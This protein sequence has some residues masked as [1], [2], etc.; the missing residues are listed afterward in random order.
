MLNLQTHDIVWLA[1]SALLCFFMQAGFLLLESGLVRSKNSINVT[2]KNI[3]DFSISMIF[4]WAFGFAIMFGLSFHGIFGTGLFLF[5]TT[6][7]SSIAMSDQSVFFLFQ[8]MFCATAVTIVSGAVAERMYFKSYLIVVAIV[9]ALVYPF[10]GHWVWGGILLGGTSGWLSEL[11]FVDFAGSLVVHGTGGWV[12]LA[13]VLILGPRRGRFLASGK[14]RELGTSSLPLAATGFLVLW[15]GWFGFNGGSNYYLDHK[16]AGILL[17]TNLAG[18]FGAITAF[19]CGWY[20]RKIASPSYLI[21]GGLG[22]LVGITANVHAV[23]EV[24]AVLIGIVSGLVMLATKFFLERVKVDDVIDVVPVHL[25]CGIWGGIAVALLGEKELLGTGLN[26]LEQLYVQSFGI[27]VSFL[28]CF[29]LPFVIFALLNWVYKFRVP[30]QWENDGL[31]L[32]EHNVSTE[33]YDF[34]Q[35]LNADVE[36]IQQLEGS[37]CLTEIGK[38]AK[39]YKQRLERDFSLQD[40]ELKERRLALDSFLAS[41]QASFT[42]GENM[43]IRGG[44][45]EGC[46]ELLGQEN[47][48]GRDVA[49]ILFSGKVKQVDFKKSFELFYDG[50]IDMDTVLRLLD[51]KTRIEAK[52]FLVEYKILTNSSVVCVLT[53]NSEK[54]RL[55]EKLLSEEEK[56]NRLIRVVSNSK[57]FD[58]FLK[59]VKG[60]FSLFNDIAVVSRHQASDFQNL[61]ALIFAVHDFKSNLAF[62]GFDYTNLLAFEL[63]DYIS[64]LDEKNFNLDVFNSKTAKIQEAF[65]D[66]LSFFKDILGE[67]WLERFDSVSVPLS[68][69]IEILDQVRTK[70]PNDKSLISD[71]E[72]LRK[73]PAKTIFKRF[74]EMAQQL[75][76]RLGKQ[77]N[78]VKVESDESFML[79]DVFAPLADVLVHMIRNMVYHGIETP[80]ERLRKGKDE[81]GNITIRIQE[82]GRNTNTNIMNGNGSNGSQNVNSYYSITFSDDGKGVD[83]EKIRQ[84]MYKRGISNGQTPTEEELLE[85]LFEPEFSTA[86]QIDNISGRGVGLANVKAEVEKLKGKIIVQT[87]K[88]QGTSFVLRIPKETH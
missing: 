55:E 22:G 86:D 15:M 27:F 26:F 60:L 65:E 66:E 8:S 25:A 16:V 2:V 88:D 21:S 33:L 41:H 40:E 10:F 17:K 82:E 87:E 64:Y 73:V 46:R 32:A 54:K 69:T 43:K 28:W 35:I 57:Y 70:Y 62:F 74:P 30:R 85:I 80:T 50:A 75:A 52:E 79:L 31:N 72:S 81:N 23:S 83:F 14:V 51:K 37:K 12:A 11:G 3:V 9:S 5:S 58:S 47:L 53:D 36:E 38:L 45:S 63:E 68:K 77:I 42:F 76:Q 7:T 6:G 48:E 49:E 4:F 44:Y 20:I 56:Q 29:A 84:L 34:Y 61:K 59:S 13:L 78:P 24:S 19:F 71:I 39:E 18:V 1:L 67:E